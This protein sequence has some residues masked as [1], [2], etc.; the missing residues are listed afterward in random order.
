[1]KILQI[2][3]FYYPRGGAEHHMFDLAALLASEG[4]TVI[5]FA[6]HHPQN[7]P[8][9]YSRYF[10]SEADFSRSSWRA[11]KEFGRVLY[12]REAKRQ[13][14]KLIA[15]ERPDIAHV[16]LLYHHLSPSVLVALKNAGIPVVLTIHDWKLLCPSYTLFTQGQPCTRCMGGHYGQAT[17][18][19]C[20]RNELLPSVLASL[21]AF[22]HHAKKYYEEYIDALVAPSH[23]VKEMFVHFGW[24]AEKIT[25]VP[26]FLSPRLPIVA[27]P[28]PAA[29]PPR[30]AYV[31]RLSPEKGV[32]ELVSY[33]LDKKIPYSLEMYGTGPLEDELRYTLASQRNG[34]RI[35]LLGQADRS[36]LWKRLATAS[37]VVVPTRMYETFGL[38]V[39][40]ALAAGIPVVASRR[41]AL[42][43]IVE[44]SHAGVLF[45]WSETG[46]PLMQALESVLKRSNDWRSRAH[47][48]ITTHHQP[49]SYYQELMA[50]YH[51]LLTNRPK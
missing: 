25:I 32:S 4:H 15:D 28:L 22:F 45:D 30:F 8:T 47:H 10:V 2:N 3:K 23:F 31:G 50:V 9:P 20:I 43:E 36:T 41:G 12:S 13:V 11:F 38:V 51:A 27:D 21:E 1:M 49:K 48:Y 39:L 37:A 34:A 40:E 16:H 42:A 5:P 44:Q 18:H 24:P 46:V 19:R 7:V 6:M 14:S 35:V 33:W 17:A 26:H 29:H